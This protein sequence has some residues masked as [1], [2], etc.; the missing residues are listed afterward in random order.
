MSSHKISLWN[1]ILIN[2]NLMIGAGIYFMPPLMAGEAGNLSYLGWPLI[3]LLFLPIVLSVAQIS[4]MLP[5]EG[6][7]YRYAQQGIHQHAGFFSGWMYFLGYVS[8]CAMQ[9]M[10]LHGE[11]AQG[12]GISWIAQ[13][14]LLFFIIFVGF[15]CA[16]NMFNLRIIGKIQSYV[17]IFK[18]LPLIFIILLLPL[19]WNQSHMIPATHSWHQLS[20]TIPFALFGFWGF[21]TC[22]SLSHR[23]EGSSSNAAKAILI[24]F[25]ATIFIYFTVHLSLIHIMG[26]KGLSTHGVSGFVNYLGITS[27]LIMK[28]I[29]TLITAS[30]LSAY[31][32]AI[33]GSLTANS[34]LLNAMAK[35]NLLYPAHILGKTNKHEQPIYA[36]CLQGS[37]MI[38]FCVLIGHKGSLAAISNIGMLITFIL[39]LISLLILQTRAGSSRRWVTVLSFISCGVLMY[40]SFKEIESLYYLVPLG[41]LGV[42]GCLLYMLRGLNKTI[43]PNQ[44]S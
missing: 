18:L 15:L 25:F 32:N 35:A 3:G 1:A 40:F 23:I 24:G 9:L 37:L 36:V 7:F 4:C 5:G 20:Y 29:D 41:I 21:E 26:A 42:A 22:A 19:L 16:L 11:L 43:A 28:L 27:P 33:F 12:V 8:I 30:I 44:E 6:S 17:T 31:I 39:T 13:N 34:F 10:A 14:S 38:L 2:I